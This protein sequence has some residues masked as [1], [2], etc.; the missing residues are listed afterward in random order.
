MH[1]KKYVSL[2]AT[3]DPMTV[4]MDRAIELIEEKRQQDQQRH[5]KEFSIDPKLKVMN[6]RFGPY[7]AYDGKNYRL[8]KNLQANASELS[9]EQCMEIVNR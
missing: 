8:P 5:L 4:T 1:K 9:Y 7:I 6:G 2:P 3:D